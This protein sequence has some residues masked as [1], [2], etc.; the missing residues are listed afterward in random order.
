MFGWRFSPGSGEVRGRFG[1]SFD[2]RFLHGF[3]HIDK[4]PYRWRNCGGGGTAP[5]KGRV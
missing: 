3:V 4:G 5:E 2:T 1:R